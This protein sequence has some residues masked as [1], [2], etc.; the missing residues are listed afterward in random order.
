MCHT[1][2]HRTIYNWSNYVRTKIQ[3]KYIDTTDVSFQILDR[4]HCDVLDNQSCRLATPLIVA[5]LVPCLEEV[6][7]K[8]SNLSALSKLYENEFGIVCGVLSG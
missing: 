3:T 2:I 4:E 1:R 5:T 8:H 7:R 6:F